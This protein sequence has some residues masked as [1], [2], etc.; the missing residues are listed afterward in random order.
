VVEMAYGIGDVSRG[1]A[2]ASYSSNSGVLASR[3]VMMPSGWGDSP[4]DLGLSHRRRGGE[5]EG[6]E[7]A[8]RG[9]ERKA[10]AKRER[11]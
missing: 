8:R 7:R 6:G 11:G 5:G 2:R 4:R 10:K 3:R 1:E 9:R